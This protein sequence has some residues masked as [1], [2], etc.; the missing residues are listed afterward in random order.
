MKPT[1]VLT[2]LVDFSKAFNRIDHNVIVTILADL[3]IPTCALRLII[4][5]LSGRKMCVRHNGAE[6]AEQHIPGGGPQGG[7][8]TVLLFDLQVKLA[9]APCPIYP[10]LPI[11]IAGPEPDPHHQAPLPVC[12]QPEK[13]MKKKYVDDLSLLETIEL[14]TALV[15][16][17][18]IIGPPNLHEQPGLTL[19]PDRSILQHQL[20]D[21]LEFTDTPRL[22]PFLVEPNA[23]AGAEGDEPAGVH[24]VLDLVGVVH[25]GVVHQLLLVGDLGGDGRHPGHLGVPSCEESLG[26]PLVGILSTGEKTG[27]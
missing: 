6:S 23:C 20:E 26:G 17:T 4:S 8:L 27:L 9:G 7:L 12:H 5:Y 21:L 1:A 19:P 18:P 15:P 11:G 10:V 13:T 25:V 24:E 3:N 22:G 14:K 2:G 16:S